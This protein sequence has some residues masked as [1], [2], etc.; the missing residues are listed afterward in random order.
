ME[1]TEDISVSV[2]KW[3]GAWRIRDLKNDFKKFIASKSNGFTKKGTE[4]INQS[5]EAFIYCILGA[6][7]RTKQSIY[8]E[9]ASALE[10]QK[11]FRQLVEDS[12][13][14]YDTSTW[15]NNMN[16]AISDTNVILNTVVSPS[17]WLLPTS[18]IILKKSNNQIQ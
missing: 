11:V 8:G 16:R 5:I 3:D 4:L 17:L 13:I 9:R 6:Q 12:I 14:N 2:R 1:N 18:L 10:T 15:T 7:A